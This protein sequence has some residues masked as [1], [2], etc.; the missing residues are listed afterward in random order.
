MKT[1]KIIQAGITLALMIVSW[2]AMAELLQGLESNLHRPYFT[3]WY[4]RKMTSQSKACTFFLLQVCPRRIRVV[5]GSMG[6][7]VLL[8]MHHS[9]WGVLVQYGLPVDI[10]EAHSKHGC[11]DVLAIDTG[12]MVMVPVPTI[13]PSWSQYN[14]VSKCQRVCFYLQHL[15]AERISNPAEDFVRRSVCAWSCL[16]CKL[17]CKL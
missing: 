2:V 1:S 3:S 13:N 14:C 6:H 4:V 5:F 11:M 9:A 17:A 16:D 12:C 8:E 10:L 15:S 7:T